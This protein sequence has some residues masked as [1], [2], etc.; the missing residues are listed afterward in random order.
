MEGATSRVTIRMA[1]RLDGFIARQDGRVDW[2][3]T[4]D[5][6]DGGETMSPALVEAFLETIDCYVM[7]GTIGQRHP[8]TAEIV[9][10]KLITDNFVSTRPSTAWRACDTTSKA[11]FCHTRSRQ[12]RLLT[13]CIFQKCRP[14]RGPSPPETA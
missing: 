3:E 2:L 14:P 1:A 8:Q 6:F 10:S 11:W 13:R 5:H 7:G 12:N 9:G 4:S